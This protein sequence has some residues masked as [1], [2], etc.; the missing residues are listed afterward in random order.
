M[1]MSVSEIEALQRKYTDRLVKVDASRAE[2]ARFAGVTGRVKTIN[3]SGRALVEFEGYLD[4]IGWYDIDLA[5]LELVETPADPSATT[6][7]K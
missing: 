3:M 5:F 6:S 7:P 4:N 1:G 2:L